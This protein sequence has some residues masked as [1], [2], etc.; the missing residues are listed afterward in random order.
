MRAA[1]CPSETVYIPAQWVEPASRL[2][3]RVAAVLAGADAAYSGSHRDRMLAWLLA[4]LVSIALCMA[5]PGYL[6]WVALSFTACELL[7]S[8]FDEETSAP[9]LRRAI[10]LAPWVAAALAALASLATGMRF[11]ALPYIAALLCV[12]ASIVVVPARASGRTARLPL[13]LGAWAM[14]AIGIA[15]EMPALAAGSGAV[16]WVSA[17]SGVILLV[18]CTS[19]IA[20]RALREHAERRERTQRTLIE[21]AR[22]Y[23]HVYYSAPVA[24]VSIDPTG[25]ILRWNEQAAQF[26]PSELRQGRL[27]TIAA[28]FGGAGAAD[29][30]R[31]VVVNGRH[32]CEVQ[33]ARDEAGAEARSFA[34][35][36]L[37]A[38]NAIEISL[39]D[40][41]ERTVLA[42]TL[43]HMAYHDTLTG[44]LNLHGLER[45]I[46]R[47]S[48]RVADGAGAS[49]LYVD[50]HRFKAINDVF[51]H[52]AGNSLVVE[53]SGRLDR[54]LPD[55]ASVA[56]LGGDEFLVVLPDCRLHAASAIA[57]RVVAQIVGEPC[58]VDGKCIRVEASVGVVEFAADMSPKELIAYASASCGEARRGGG[59]VA[60]QSSGEH[61]AKYRAE[62]ELGQRLRTSL[63]IERMRV[64]AQ[65]IVPL[66]IPGREHAS[67]ACEVLLRECDAQGNILPP[68][69]L[70]EAA[71]R[72]GAMR[73]IDAFMLERTLAHLDANRDWARSLDFVTVNLSGSSLNDERFL[74]DAHAL[75]SQC[76]AAAGKLCLE[77]TESIAM[78]DMN[79]TRR[80]VERMRALGV[81]IALDDFGAGFSSFAYL[82]ELPASMIKID[83]QFMPGIDRHERNQV[84]V[85]GIRRLTEDLGMTCVAEWVEDAAALEFLLRVEMDYAQG[86]ALARPKPI[87]DWL[88]ASVDLGVLVEARRRMVHSVDSE[89]VGNSPARRDARQRAPIRASHP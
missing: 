19:V 15:R 11:E 24:L 70:I 59:V 27:N 47:L 56:R 10:R 81:R 71:E 69:R 73:A 5:F 30:L 39:V 33:L 52:A 2:K 28:L 63:P 80:F 82:R 72:H 40:I 20:A 76:G 43:E 9:R 86:Y 65:P 55:D 3:S 89:T 21:T 60:A 87:E 1:A 26:F 6:A 12:A 36:A 50:L 83:G 37:L 68:Q 42:R 8:L 32:R 18:L 58:D 84:I 34:V 85:A 7:L 75:L 48:E 51:G 46:T 4:W 35:D 44:R 78:F 53:V 49:L 29:L 66:R 22:Q 14:H 57:Q 38:G 16:E 74:A 31:D 23:R 79:S 61:L 64:F 54:A 77:I 67:M 17:N 88:G 62:V 41:T 25:Q 45:E 13:F